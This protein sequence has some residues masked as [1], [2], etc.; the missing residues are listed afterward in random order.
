MISIEFLVTIATLALVFAM[1]AQLLN[2][3]AAWG[4][5]WDLGIAGLIGVGA[6]SYVLLTTAPDASVPGLGLSWP[7]G[8]LGAGVITGLVALLLGWPALRLRGEYFLITTFAFAEILR[9]LIVIQ[10]GLTGGTFGLTTIVKPWEFQFTIDGYPYVR[11]ILTMAL[12]AVVFGICSRLATSSYGATL[13]AARD[14]EPLAMA[15]GKKIKTLRLS[16]YATVGVM[17]GLFVGPAYAWMLG[18][19]VPSVFS[20]HLTFTLWAGLVIGGLG[21][22]FGPVLGA[23]LLTGMSELVRLVHVPAEFANLHAAA[24]PALV[25]LLL[26]IVLR[27]RPAGLLSEAGT[28]ARLRRRYQRPG[29]QPAGTAEAAPASD[30]ILTGSAHDRNA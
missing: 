15:M 17:C 3:E 18:A 16:T 19:L 13:R 8:M 2:L 25:G 10:K 23:L 27:W 12:T 30:P 28:F 21:S 6:Y 1:A 20:S 9:Q 29:P 22:R 24:H 7:L 11:L 14:N 5:M 26:I 4:G